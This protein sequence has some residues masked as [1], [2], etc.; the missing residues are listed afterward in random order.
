VAAKQFE[1][2]PQ[3]DLPTNGADVGYYLPRFNTHPK[4]PDVALAQQAKGSLVMYYQ[5]WRKENG[6]DSRYMQALSQKDVVPIVTWEPWDSAKGE[7]GDRTQSK[8]SP[9][10]IARGDYDEYVHAWARQ[11]AVHKKIFFIRFAH[12][13]NG[14]WYPW[15]VQK[16]NTPEDYR[17]MWRHV[18]NI[19]QEEG[20]TNVLWVWAPNNESFM[21]KGVKIEDYYPGSD[22]VDWVGYSAFNWGDTDASRDR[23]FLEVAKDTYN[24]IGQFGKPIMVAEMAT[25]GTPA[26]KSRWY[27]DAN[28]AIK[29]M[30]GIKA[31]IFYIQDFNEYEFD[32]I[33]EPETVKVVQSKFITDSYFV[34]TPLEH[35]TLRVLGSR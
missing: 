33:Q 5:D 2:I 29:T 31:I 18:H 4:N 35:T 26:Q 25:V 13:M 8:Y 15:A 6:F 11:A 9:K 10:R 14:N 1:R 28:K 34:S 24:W 3:F 23:P 17:R 20:A 27:A 22:V 19:F 32:F 21:Q 30:P 16:G 12:E 7:K